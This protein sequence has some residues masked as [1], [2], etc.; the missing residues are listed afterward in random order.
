[1]DSAMCD[2]LLSHDYRDGLQYC[3]RYHVDLVTNSHRHQHKLVEEEVS[4]LSTLGATF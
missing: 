2:V 1:M 3:K 4:Q